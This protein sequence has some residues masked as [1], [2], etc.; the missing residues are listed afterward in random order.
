M[1][2]LNY[3]LASVYSVC[4]L[5]GVPSNCVS[6]W[7][8]RHQKQHTSTVIHIMINVIDLLITGFLC[9]PVILTGY[10]NN[11]QPFLFKFHPFCYLW[12]LLY[13][14]LTKISVFMLVVLS[15]MRTW[16]I[17]RPF[18]KVSKVYIV[19]P[20]IVYS[21]YLI[22]KNVLFPLAIEFKVAYQPILGICVIS[23]FNNLTDHQ[24]MLIKVLVTTSYLESA[25][26]VIPITLCSAITLYH[27]QI[28]RKM[29][30]NTA[31]QRR[32][33]AGVTVTILTIVYLICTIPYTINYTFGVIGSWSGYYVTDDIENYSKLLHYMLQNIIGN[34]LLMNTLSSTINPIVFIVRLSIVQHF[35]RFLKERNYSI[36]QLSS[37]RNTP[38]IIVKTVL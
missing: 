28:E 17:C 35:L 19:I 6:I 9:F 33:K 7:Y 37:T 38:R 22:L 2:Q 31:Q 5:V 34:A 26:P 15:A 14:Y 12:N 1:F 18:T 16:S 27:L 8:F 13:F 20:Y 32:H 23:A 10:S 24:W 36:S 29:Q 11:T 3:F 4:L 30:P 25:L 21:I